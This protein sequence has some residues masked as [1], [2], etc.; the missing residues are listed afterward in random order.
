[1]SQAKVDR[2]K[3]NKAN[4]KQTMARNKRNHLIGV[5]CGWIVAIAL[6]GWIGQSAYQVYLNSQPIETIYADLTP[7]SDYLTDITADE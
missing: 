7:I 2:N 6:L 1:M 5:I 3:E 4:R